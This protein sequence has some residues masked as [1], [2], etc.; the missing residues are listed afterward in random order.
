[1][2]GQ[3]PATDSGTVEQFGIVLEQGSSLTSCVSQ[4]VEA[5]RSDGTLKKLESTWLTDAAGAPLLK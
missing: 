1:V 2:V 5:L 3:L 4:A